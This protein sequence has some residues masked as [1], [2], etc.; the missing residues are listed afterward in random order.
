MYVTAGRS[1]YKKLGKDV[2]NF[3][4]LTLRKRPHTPYEADAW[5]RKRA[6]VNNECLF[7]ETTDVGTPTNKDARGIP[8]VPS[9]SRPPFL[10][11]LNPPFSSRLDFS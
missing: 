6:K 4:Q 7:Y 11:R 8:K 10:W 5:L 9:P 2:Y 1:L 3:F